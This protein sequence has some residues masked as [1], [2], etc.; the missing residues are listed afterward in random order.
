MLVVFSMK[1]VLAQTLP[2]I[3]ILNAPISAP[4]LMAI[5]QSVSAQQPAII[6]VHGG[7]PVDQVLAERGI[8]VS[9]QA[10]K[11]LRNIYISEKQTC[12]FVAQQQLGEGT[13]ILSASSITLDCN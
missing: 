7:Q 2:Q 11:E 1:V 6:T 9:P 5:A 4:D 10:S 8:K 13:Q 3:P 12:V